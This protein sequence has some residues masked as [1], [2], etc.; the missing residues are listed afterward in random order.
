MLHT[1]PAAHRK[2]Y[3]FHV[4]SWED[5]QKIAFKHVSTWNRC[6]VFNFSCFVHFNPP[7]G[8]AGTAFNQAETKYVFLKMNFLRVEVSSKLATR[9][10]NS[11]IIF[12]NANHFLHQVQFHQN[13]HVNISNAH[14]DDVHTFNDR[15]QVEHKWH[16]A[17]LWLMPRFA[18][19]KFLLN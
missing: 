2:I 10:T 15:L 12:H 14:N 19:Y 11:T 18:C 3:F 6:S 7:Y 16:T 1:K 17:W 8:W 9:P 13:V 4:V 5:T